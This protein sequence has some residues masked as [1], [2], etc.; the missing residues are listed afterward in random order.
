MDAT[1]PISKRMPDTLTENKKS[2]TKKT[3]TNEYFKGLIQRALF[4]EQFEERQTRVTC[5]FTQTD[6]GAFTA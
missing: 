6:I 5:S 3:E 1:T 4:Y 2:E